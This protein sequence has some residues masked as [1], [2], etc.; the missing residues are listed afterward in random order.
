MGRISLSAQSIAFT[1]TLVG[2]NSIWTQI[3]LSLNHTG[4]KE[5]LIL[6]GRNRCSSGTY[7]AKCGELG[8]P[9]RSRMKCSWCVLPSSITSVCFKVTRH[10]CYQTPLARFPKLKDGLA[11]EL[12]RKSYG[13]WCP[14]WDV[15]DG[16]SC[17]GHNM[18]HSTSAP[19]YKWLVTLTHL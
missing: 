12:L 18:S 1:S 3:Q 10:L 7:E 19:S 11:V 9:A 4:G 17:L 2:R 14:V 15:P 16:T 13:T 8:S 5:S 6:L